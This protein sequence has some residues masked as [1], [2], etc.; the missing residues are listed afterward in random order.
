MLMRAEVK[1][2]NSTGVGR[3]AEEREDIDIRNDPGR[4]LQDQIMDYQ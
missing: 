4:L 2:K 1:K 3:Q